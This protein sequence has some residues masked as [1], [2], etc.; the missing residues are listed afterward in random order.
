MSITYLFIFIGNN[1][2]TVVRVDNFRFIKVTVILSLQVKHSDI[3]W[4]YYYDLS[5]KNHVATCKAIIYSFD[6]EYEGS[7]H[8]VQ[9]ENTRF[10]IWIAF[11]LLLF[12]SVKNVL[13][14]VL[15]RNLK[16]TIR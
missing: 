14:F 12:A 1:K 10:F 6:T 4:P 7:G 8:I 9:I 11:F 5:E 16:K 2:K 3:S 15:T 13:G